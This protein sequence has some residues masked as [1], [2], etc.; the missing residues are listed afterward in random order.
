MLWVMLPRIPNPYIAPPKGTQ[1]ALDPVLFGPLHGDD[2][3]RMQ[4]LIDEDDS[5]SPFWKWI[6]VV[7]WLMLATFLVLAVA[8]WPGTGLILVPVGI[9]TIIASGIRLL[10]GRI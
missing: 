6:F 8:G 3:A 7:G 10:L 9:G 4:Q 2:S 5:D 1:D